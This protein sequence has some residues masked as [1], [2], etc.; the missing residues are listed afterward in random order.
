MAILTPKTLGL[1]AIAVIL[2]GL[3]FM[4]QAQQP[5]PIRVALSP[6]PNQSMMANLLDPEFKTEHRTPVS[7]IPTPWPDIMQAVA[8]G[9]ADLGFATQIDLRARP[10]DEKDPLQLVYPAFAFKDGGF[11]AYKAEVPELDRMM[12]RAVQASTVWRWLDFR[13]GVQ[14]DSIFEVM[15]FH[16]A[17]THGAS[18]DKV[19]KVYMQIE[20][21]LPAAREDRVD[22]APAG[23]IPPA[24]KQRGARAVLTMADLGFADITA[25]IVRKSVY[26]RRFRQIE[27]VIEM[28]FD[29]VNHVFSDLAA[30]SKVSLAY[31]N[32]HAPKPYTAEEYRAKLSEE[33]FP[34]T[35]LKARAELI[36]RSGHFSVQTMGPVIDAYWKH[37][38]SRKES[39]QLQQVP[40]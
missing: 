5:E 10:Q 2:A 14:R 40:R 39:A 27:A 7:L 26:E 35:R 15:L 19:N 36:D 17:T 34:R 23:G 9:R 11:V 12:I 21:G 3:F 16:L 30:N 32:S 31:L 25:F 22:I 37:K 29:S 8:S 38:R 24:E 18:F 6:E 20:Q 4:Y 33:Y 1:I 28:W 13:I